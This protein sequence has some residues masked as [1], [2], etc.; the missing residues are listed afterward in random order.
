MRTTTLRLYNM[1]PPAGRSIA[2]SLQGL[3]LRSWRYGPDTDARVAE[4]LERDQWSAERWR[5]WQEERLAFVLRRAATRVPYY[6]RLWE[7]RRRRGDRASFER[8]EN[9]PILEKKRVREVPESFVADDCDVRNMYHEQTSGTTGTPLHLWCSR[10]KVR[11][12]FALFEARGRRWNGVTR[13]DRWA[14]AGGQLVVP[15]SRQKPPFWVWIVPMRQLY[16]S[17][18]HL[19]RDRVAS[20]FD[21]MRRYRVTHVFGY[22]SSMATLAQNALELNVPSLSLKVALSNAEPLS[23]TQRDRISA[24]FGCPVRDTY[25]M[26]ETVCGGSECAEGTMHTWPEA[27][28][29]EVLRDSAWDPMPAGE[30]GQLV[31]TGLLN[32]DMPL[33]RYVVGDRG[34]LAEDRLCG[35]GRGLPALERIDGRSDDIL[36]TPDGRRIGRLD[37]IFK[38]DLPIREAQIIQEAPNRVRVK[39]VAASRLDAR[40]LEMVRDRLWQRMGSSVEVILETVDEIPRGPGGK[41]RAVVS[42]LPKAVGDTV[43]AECPP[44]AETT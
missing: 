12:L 4:A 41:F 33:I 5:V 17:S 36:V 15:V 39:M 32:T 24:A 29:I 26:A 7:E 25:G 11:E 21:A 44:G 1:L 16:L 27:G 35:C 31:C 6:R 20:Y 34:G 3:V 42:L 18:Y 2:A 19:S 30:T 10:E 37:P 14:M 8:L 9:W 13:L 28:V 43:A 23:A 38:A 22:A 40:D